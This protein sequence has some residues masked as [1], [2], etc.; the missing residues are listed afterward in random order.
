MLII[1]ALVSLYFIVQMFLGD[2]SAQTI[3][4]K[5]QELK[6]LINQYE[7]NQADI[8]MHEKQIKAL[9]TDNLDV[10]ILESQMREKMLFTKPNE[11]M[12]IAPD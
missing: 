3:S 10:D 9:D 11:I 6:G 1:S 8:M 4:G 5:K 12:L 7:R 2:Y